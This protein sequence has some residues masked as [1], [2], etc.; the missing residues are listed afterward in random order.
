MYSV[1]ASTTVSFSNTSGASRILLGN[2]DTG[3]SNNPALIQGINGELYF[4]GGD[5]WVGGGNN[6]ISMF[7]Q[8][9]GNVGIGT[10]SP[11]SLLE[12]SNENNSSVTPLLTLVNSDANNN[13][14]GIRLMEGSSYNYGFSIMYDD[15]GTFGTSN[16][17][18][19]LRH[20]NS[21]A[22]A[23]FMTALRSNGRIGFGTTTPNSLV[24][25]KT[26][27]SSSIDPTNHVTEALRLVAQYGEDW[28]SSAHEGGV[29]I[30]FMLD[31]QNGGYWPAGEINFIGENS[32]NDE[33]H[34]G[35]QFKVTNNNDSGN[36]ETTASANTT[37]MVLNYEGKV[38]IGTTTP[39]AKLE[40]AGTTRITDLAGTGDR[41]VVANA[42]GDLSTQAIPSGSNS[43]SN[44]GD[45]QYWDGSTWQ[46]I[47]AG[48]NGAVL[49]LVSGVPTWVSSPDITA[50]NVS[51]VGD[52]NMNI[53][54]NGTFTD[55]GA[56]TDEGTISTSG[57]VDVS[58]VG[59]YTLTYSATDATGNTG[60]ATRTVS[61]YQS[62]FNY[63]GSA[64]TFIVPPGVTSYF[65]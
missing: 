35:F 29:G 62:Q 17:L 9:N 63:T 34:G 48:S 21:S 51:L 59:T 50:P 46:N 37:A 55:P 31:N 23:P 11:S 49:Q 7:I 3:G 19:L 54:L 20:D 24:E 38:G 18:T 28:A 58:T 22:G 43:G 15:N 40:V 36:D 27:V 5:N 41:M 61:V 53:V 47:P 30:K 4:G 32:D 13:Y 33:G 26:E 10:T 1:A 16:A 6:D 45:M 60:T 56:T 57:T 12:I 25:I 64:Q 39:N 65:C 44:V 14:T 42:D 2:Q 52:A 8:D